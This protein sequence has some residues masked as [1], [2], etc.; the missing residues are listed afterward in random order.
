MDQI[1]KP[2]CTNIISVKKSLQ[3]FQ[4]QLLPTGSDSIPATEEEIAGCIKFDGTNSQFN[5]L[6][7]SVDLEH[8]LSST[9]DLRVVPFHPARVQNLQK[10]VDIPEKA[11]KFNC[12]QNAVKITGRLRKNLDSK[13]R[14]NKHKYS[15]MPR[16]ESD[17]EP[18]TEMLLKIRFYEPFKYKPG[19]RLGHPKFHQE[20][21]VLG[22]QG[23]CELRD[24]I[25]CQCDLGPFYDIST[26]PNDAM[27]S[28]ERDDSKPNP[29]F[30]F[31]HDTFYNDTRNKE[32]PDYSEVICNW[33]E[34]QKYIG[35]LKTKKMEEAKFE[36]LV[37]RLGYPQVY[38]HH[39]NC[40]HLF[41][42]SD[43][44]LLTASD[45]LVRKR[46]PILNSYAFPRSIPCNICGHCE[47]NFIVKNSDQHIFD[48]AYICQVCFESYHYKDGKKLGEFEAFRFLGTKI[49]V[50]DDETE[51]ESRI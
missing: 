5:D 30:F 8:N 19:I 6:L 32:N 13:I 40:E 48:P 10:Q 28:P 41:V 25:Y 15:V 31:V 3:E 24:K 29:G 27:K 7:Q 20:F 4:Q 34:R 23:L 46:Y 9:K 45:V 12:V 35:Q 47:A 16:E 33:A 14:Y 21:F 22:S 50:K 38:Q 17:I 37:F 39:G 42:I 2:K 51:I 44:Q 36:D 18:Y 1:Y 11:L 43:C 49:A 26:I